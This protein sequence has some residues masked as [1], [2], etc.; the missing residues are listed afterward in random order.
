MAVTFMRATLAGLHVI[1]M[2]AG[3]AACNG[4]IDG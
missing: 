3:T 1:I 2:A 4:G